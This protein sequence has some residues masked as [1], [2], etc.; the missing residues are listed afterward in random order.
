[1]GELYW[2][3]LTRDVPFVEYDTNPLTQAAAVDLSK[4]SVFKGPKAGG[5]VTT[6]TLFRGTTQEISLD[7]IFPIFMEEQYLWGTDDC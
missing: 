1:M 7:H 6:G 2:Q 4:F 3:A 5:V